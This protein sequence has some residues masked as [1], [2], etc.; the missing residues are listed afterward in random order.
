[1]TTEQSQPAEIAEEHPEYLVAA[2][3]I[4]GF[5]LAQILKRLGA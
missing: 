1:M 5:A 2:A 4:G 3:F